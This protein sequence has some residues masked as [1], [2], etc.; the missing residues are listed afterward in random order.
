MA[1]LLVGLH[2]CASFS[3][4]ERNTVVHGFDRARIHTLGQHHRPANGEAD[5]PFFSAGFSTSMPVDFM[6]TQA[7]PLAMQ[8]STMSA[9]TSCAA[10]AS[11]DM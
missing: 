1:T 11:A 5:Q 9:P 6:F 2:D 10:S 3:Q 8:S 4:I 7:Q